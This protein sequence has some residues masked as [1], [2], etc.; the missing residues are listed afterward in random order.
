MA[1]PKDFL[2][3]KA[4]L[5]L[6][7]LIMAFFVLWPSCPIK[8]AGP[9]EALDASIGAAGMAAPGMPV[10]DYGVKTILTGFNTTDGIKETAKKWWQTWAAKL[11]GSTLRTTINRI[12]Y[13]A[14]TAIATAGEGQKPLWIVEDLGTYIDNLGDAA[15]GDFIAGLGE[16]WE[17]D[18]CQPPDPSIK[19]RIGLGLVSAQRPST[20]NCTLS[21]LA[22]NYSSAY[23]KYKAMKT[24]DYL[25]AVQVAFEPG[26]GEIGTAFTLFGRT[27][28]ID[29]N[30]KKN[31]ETNLNVKGQW[32]D[33]RS[34][35]GKL[36][37]LPDSQKTALQLAQEN[38][39]ASLLSTTGDALIDAA[40][41]FLNQL[42]YE[43]MQRG[44]RELGKAQTTSSRYNYS[45]SLFESSVQY[46]KNLIS[47]KLSSFI[48]PRFNVKSDYNILGELAVCPDKKNPG[49]NNC[50][51]DDNFSQ[52]IAEKLTV[53]EAFEKGYLHP[54]WVVSDDDKKENTYTLR[55][56]SILRKFRIVPVGW[57]EAIKRAAASSTTVTLMDLMACYS[58]SDKY[59][60]SSNFDRN[61]FSWCANLVDPHWLLKVPASS[62][63]KQGVGA[64]IL[65]SIPTRDDNGLSTVQLSR[66]EEYC[67]DEQ[68]C[69]KEK[70]DGSCTVMGYCNEEKRTWDF[71]ADSCE[72]V[73]NTCQEFT[74]L[75]TQSSIAYL[76]NTL[77]YGSCSSANVGCKQ[78]VYG[79][80]YNITDKSVTWNPSQ[81]LYLDNDAQDCNAKD[82]GCTKL[83]RGKPLWENVNFVMNSD[84]SQNKED[85]SLQANN[86]KWPVNAS[87]AKI[88][89]YDGARALYLEGNSSVNVYSDATHNI[90]PQGMTVV[91][92]WAYTLSAEVYLQD[93]YQATVS[94]TENNIST[95][96]TVRGSWQVLRASVLTSEQDIHD[97]KFSI[98]GTGSSVKMYVRNIQL[99][100]NNGNNPKY[101]NYANY[102]AYP[103]YEKILPAYLESACYVNSGNGV[104]DYRFKE[105][106]PKEV[107][108]NFA[109]KCN[110]EEVGCDRFTA[111]KDGFKAVAKAQPADYCWGVCAGYDTYIAH[112]S[113]FYD[114]VAENIIPKNSKACS[115][116]N[117]GCTG[118]T[119]LDNIAQGGEKQEYYTYV[120]QCIKPDAY[121]CGDFYSWEGTNTGGYQLKAASLRKD[122]SGNP[123]LVNDSLASACT[124]EIYYLPT[125]DPRFNPDCREFY[126][127]NGSI[128][129]AA[130]SN[131]FSCSADCHPYR[132]NQK[133]IDS[134]L[135][136]TSCNKSNM[137]WNGSE[138]NCYVCKS[139]GTWSSQYNACIYNAVPNEGLSCVAEEE[140]CREYNGNGGGNLRLVANYNF[141][142]GTTPFAAVSGSMSQSIEST[143]KDGHSLS[144]S[145]GEVQAD[146][147]SQVKQGSSYIIKFMA[148]ASAPVT[149]NAYFE[150]AQR[151][152]ALF[153]ASDS[154]TEGNLAISGNNFWKLYEI[155]VSGIDHKIDIEKLKIKAS[156]Q[157]FIDNITIN[158]ITDRFYLIKGSSNIP[159]ECYY[160]IFNKYQGPNYN[161]GCSS[162]RD[163]LGNQHYLHRFSE[164]CQDSAA[165]CEQM[166]QTNNS[167]NPYPKNINLNNIKASCTSG[168]A[169][170]LSVPGHK[171]VYAVYNPTKLCVK[172][173]AGC[174]RFAYSPANTG[175]SPWV[176]KYK[177]NLPDSY[178]AT[179][180]QHNEVGCEAWTYGPNAS[181]T[182]FKD[183]G[184]NVC[185]FKAGG[186]YKGLES[187]CD[188][189]NDNIIDNSERS[190][191]NCSSDADCGSARC[192]GVPCDV[193]YLKTIGNGG[194][195]GAVPTPS[196][197]AGICNNDS[198]GCTEFIDPVSSYMNNIL[199]GTAASSY[200]VKYNALYTANAVDSA[201]TI[202]GGNNLRVLGGNNEL[203]YAVPSLSV[204]L[205]SSL[206]FYTGMN[207][208]INVIGRTASTTIKETII[209][210]KK[211]DNID[212]SSCEGTV[213]SENGCVLF[214]NRSRSGGVLKFNALATGTNGKTIACVGSSSDCSANQ[215]I[216]VR[217]DRICS[218]WL[219][220]TSYT[221][222]PVTFERT[223][224][225]M[226]ECDKL[227]DK[228]ECAN[229]IP[230]NTDTRT[231]NATTIANNQ[232]STGYSLLNNYYLGSMKEVGQNADAHFDFEN[233][234]VT[235]SCKT[236]EGKNCDE[237]FVKNSLVLEPADPKRSSVKYPAHGRGYLKVLSYYKLSPLAENSFINVYGNQDYYLNFL[238]NTKDS[239]DQARVII[240]NASGTTII[241]SSTFKT[242]GDWERK[243]IKFKAGTTKSIQKIKIY[244]TT[245]AAATSTQNS[246]VYFDDINIEPVLEVAPNKYVAKD[247][248]LYPGADSLTCLSS[249]N[250]VIKDGLFGYCLQ[251]DPLN[252]NS[253]LMWY[254]I[255]KIAPITRSTQANY[256]YQGKFPLYYCS[257]VNGDFKVLK[258]I[259]TFEITHDFGGAN[260]WGDQEE[261]IEEQALAN[262]FGEW[263]TNYVPVNRCFI[264]PNP[265]LN[266]GEII[267]A[268]SASN[269]SAKCGSDN[270]RLMYNV[271]HPGYHIRIYCVPNPDKVLIRTGEDTSPNAFLY[272]DQNQCTPELVGDAW[273]LD[274]GKFLSGQVF[275]SEQTGG[276]IERTFS[277]KQ[278]LG[279]IN[280]S[281]TLVPD[282]V[283]PLF[284]NDPES[285]YRL[286]CNRFSQV[287]DS[288][289][290]NM[291]WVNRVSLNSFPTSTPSFFYNIPEKFSYT[292][293]LYPPTVKQGLYPAACTQNSDCLPGQNCSNYSAD[294]EEKPHNNGNYGCDSL[295]EQACISNY[296]YCNWT[297]TPGIC[298][299]TAVSKAIY[300]YGRNREDVPFGA[301]IFPSNYSLVDSQPI[302]LRN[303]YSDNNRETIFAGRPYG[304]AG[305]GCKYVGQ[306]NLNPNIF[307]IYTSSEDLN[308][309]GCASGG[310]GECA[311]LWEVPLTATSSSN[312]LSSLFVKKYADF[313]LS[314]GTY[315]NSSNSDWLSPTT[316]CPV[317]GRASTSPASFC[318]VRPKIDNV[319]IRLVGNPSA[320]TLSNSNNYTFNATTSGLYKL[321]F[322]SVVDSEQ[323]PLKQIIIDWNDDAGVQIMTGLDHKPNKP[324]PHEFFHYYL[325]GGTKRIGITILDNWDSSFSIG[326]LFP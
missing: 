11:V 231:I 105:G 229:V 179:L 20:P 162:Y 253:C 149:L 50:V 196:S 126:N 260:N 100:P 82:E 206:I 113:Y 308:K 316:T 85:D 183:P 35:A 177:K 242:N 33:V 326:S 307:C 300:A 114:A 295:P 47:E 39:S 191:V 186:W 42:A 193:T 151:E 145:G 29:L 194:Y 184:T 70:G 90:L 325:G 110:S 274:D 48:K 133:N 124:K 212:V 25:K 213:N 91:P 187:R 178:D 256:G 207:S 287:V 26:G 51:I 152:K 156:G 142:S 34:P 176:D 188:Y 95:S 111:D 55:S 94:F 225:E 37:G 198:A 275:S 140:G 298:T 217:P 315:I 226:G 322:N 60:F 214:N 192:I 22:T 75:S 285:S 290:N 265:Q 284:S 72:P 302:P 28:D 141:E 167:L 209:N 76:E 218:R 171:V 2:K 281:D 135:D 31:A 271:A 173:D 15:A 317:A 272:Q 249:N 199:A 30:G 250:N 87:V 288:E 5:A 159:D 116:Q 263:A 49:P 63:L 120:R 268:S 57:E 45:S 304:C 258:K 313:T 205:G 170:C 309:K 154:N 147:S 181:P 96:T 98:N 53:A 130:I 84:F 3:N 174:T 69:I 89:M 86:L 195:N 23:E 134:N 224:Y 129:Y 13:D 222:D 88:T 66:A 78:Y 157:V 64:Q 61:N 221:E 8:A 139:G 136:A 175:T 293:K 182:Y 131:T 108:D 180:C 40:N 1:S 138:G 118:F 227:N 228:N 71:N 132:M 310:G 311:R 150:N 241:A 234:S 65:S 278:E 189:N 102:G 261:I 146:V 172:N 318:I 12:A 201:L 117:A 238:A 163:S 81:S 230:A 280:N 257:E 286:V 92:G 197:A 153:N 52:A 233:G 259:R 115:A 27:T 303:Q 73:Y 97:L 220:C 208:S 277:E 32:L 273:V 297:S 269:R 10:S 155:N 283:K 112:E 17:V 254:P 306:C 21:Q 270:Y 24:G 279:I 292:S 319:E 251:Y 216:K 125:S 289:S 122:A 44:L 190:R 18:L 137:H 243:I 210:Y 68:S 323:Q 4:S 312:I 56:A 314:N 144:I 267:T 164:L 282:N 104:K 168:S 248:R 101:A 301:A 123:F 200:K 240:T 6:T 9:F 236:L 67:A 266:D 16:K 161:L 41:I 99:T 291:S 143:S 244:L 160:D 276:N 14:A 252:T 83:L 106:Y 43:G 320:I 79:G 46:G 321:S 54:D 128:T 204:P 239:A 93:G 107:C 223:C 158:E 80:T 19:V 246:Y 237:K 264:S 165:G 36:R 127:K 58:T 255:D 262:M 324:M 109:R 235:L 219:S 59:E 202:S 299:G 38:Q 185:V 148:K 77:D 119:N 232:N 215:L 305:T 247:C 166:I 211:T 74:N 296:A 245:D 294:C 103:L 169:D 62:C 7:A 121:S 203:G